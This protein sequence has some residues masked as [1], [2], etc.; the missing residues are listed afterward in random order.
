M[1]LVLA[2]RN[3]G[4]IREMHSVL[5][6]L[7]V[8]ILSAL[9]YPELPPVAE[10]GLTFRDNAIKKAESVCSCLGLPSLADDS[11][12]EIDFLDGQPGVFS[13]RFA[14]P[15]SD[16]R[17]NIAKVLSLLSGIPPEKRN[18]RFRC[19]I[20]LAAPGETT[21]TVEG[22]CSGVI[23]AEPR[24]IAGFG[25]DPIFIVP[26]YDQT[27]AELGPE[28]KNRISHRARALARARLLLQDLRPQP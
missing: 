28:I 21:R 4:K 13:S 11:G 26:E 25:Y 20:A 1:T 23:A 17:M 24:G 5:G 3:R 18:A 8:R 15:E 14:G 10:D 16:D 9:D 22:Q 2:T 19:I 27:F 12:L 7:P 6:D